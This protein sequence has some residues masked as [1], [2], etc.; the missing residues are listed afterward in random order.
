M[1]EKEVFFRF[2]PQHDKM[3]MLLSVTQMNC[4]AE[5]IRWAFDDI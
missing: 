3:A 2:E 5:E 1:Y 4:S